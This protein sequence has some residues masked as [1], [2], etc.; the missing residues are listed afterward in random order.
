MVPPCP[1]I[2]PM[3][4]LT[5]RQAAILNLYARQCAHPVELV[6]EVLIHKVSVCNPLLPVT[7]SLSDKLPDYFFWRVSATNFMFSTC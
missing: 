7:P 6:P 2:T 4:R 1:D 5:R 3:P